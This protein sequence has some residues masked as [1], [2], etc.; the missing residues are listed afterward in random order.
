MQPTARLPDQVGLDQKFARLTDGVSS[1][2]G[3]WRRIGVR[4]SLRRSATDQMKAEC[5]RPIE[6][7]DIVSDYAAA[8][9]T[10]VAGSRPSPQPSPLKGGGG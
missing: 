4:H 10:V 7:I 5:S 8:F 3:P 6:E 9:I 1:A 2:V